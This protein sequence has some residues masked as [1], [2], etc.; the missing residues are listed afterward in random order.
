MAATNEDQIPHLHES[1]TEPEPIPVQGSSNYFWKARTDHRSGD[2]AAQFGIKPSH[3]V[4][5][6]I[7]DTHFTPRTLHRDLEDYIPT[8]L[9]FT[10]P[11]AESER[12]DSWFEETFKHLYWTTCSFSILRL[13]QH[14]FHLPT[15]RSPWRDAKLSTQFLSFASQ[16]SH[17]DPLLGGWD[18]VLTDKTHRACLVTGILSKVLVNSVFSNLLWGAT[19]EQTMLLEAHDAA[20]LSDDGFKRTKRRADIVR[21]ALGGHILTPNFWP[22]VDELAAQ[23]TSLLLPL[24]NFQ[25][26]QAP[27]EKWPGLMVIYQELHDII[28]EAAYFSI[29]IRL[30]H[31]ILHIEYPEPGDKWELD[32]SHLEGERIY[33]K[34]KENAQKYDTNQGNKS[35][36]RSAR[37]AKVKV[38][39]WPQIKR[40]EPLGSVENYG[41]E[42]GERVALVSRCEV[43]YYYGRSDDQG[44]MWERKPTLAEHVLSS[45][46]TT[47]R[48]EQTLLFFVPLLILGLLATLAPL[49][50]HNALL[51]GCHAIAYG[52]RWFIIAFIGRLLQIIGGLLYGIQSGPLARP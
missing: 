43:A 41:A 2:W 13:G 35:I 19:D 9:E 12:K 50:P 8:R 46:N 39:A 32:H 27:T 5:N 22:R 25:G 45:K 23:T 52:A 21:D 37:I 28:A 6:P 42:D 24:I 26:Q 29:C 14:N 20:T 17:Q 3:W 7:I 11:H 38:I 47:P 1:R 40:H 49:S 10:L 15:G 34:S 36:K 18:L 16:L 44:E 48:I 4:P 30:S 31:T 33:Q 51:R